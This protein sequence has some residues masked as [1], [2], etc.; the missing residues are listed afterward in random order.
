M[1]ENEIILLLLVI[2]SFLVIIATHYVDVCSTV[3]DMHYVVDDLHIL[4]PRT[5]RISLFVIHLTSSFRLW[6]IMIGLILR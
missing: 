1:V 6:I 4:W 3:I 5:I 2:I